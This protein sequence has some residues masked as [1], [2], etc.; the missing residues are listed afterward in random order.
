MIVEAT[1]TAHCLEYT[2]GWRKDRGT[3]YVGFGLAPPAS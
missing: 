1:R 3:F 2:V